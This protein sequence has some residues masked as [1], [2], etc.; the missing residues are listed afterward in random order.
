MVEASCD[1]VMRQPPWPCCW[2][3]SLGMGVKKC[4]ATVVCPYLIGGL[5]SAVPDSRTL[6]IGVALGVA[7]CLVLAVNSSLAIANMFLR[8][9]DLLCE[10]GG[11]LGHPPVI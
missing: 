5:E 8:I 2:W 10:Y 1:R 3:V 4:A 7:G 6:P 9:Y 11:S